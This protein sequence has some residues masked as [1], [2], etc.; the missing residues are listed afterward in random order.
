MQS[1]GEPRLDYLSAILVFPGLKRT[2][3]TTLGLNNLSAVWIL[4][5]LHFAWFPRGFWGHISGSHRLRIEDQHH[6]A[7][8]V[9]ILVE[10]TVLPLTEN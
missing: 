5:D 8:A 9:A 6:L 7:Q 10:Q 1:I 4:V 3:I 2:L